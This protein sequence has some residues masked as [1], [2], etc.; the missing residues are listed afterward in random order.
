MAFD[1]GGKVTQSAWLGFDV[2]RRLAEMQNVE[3]PQN[4]AAPAAGRD[5]PYQ[6]KPDRYSSHAVLLSRLDQANGRRLLDVGAADGYLAQILTKRGFEV[7]CLEGNPML[8]ARAQGKCASV[9]VSD[10]NREVPRMNGTYDAIVYGDILEHLQ[11]PLN[12]LT[13]LNRNLAPGGMVLIS[14]P[15][16][17][18][19]WVRMQLILGRFEYADRGILD[20]THLRFFTL[21]SFKQFIRDSGLVLDELHATPVPLPLVVPERYQGRIFNVLHSMNAALARAWKTMFA[22]QFIG[23]C[24][25]SV[26]A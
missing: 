15:N 20:R 14:V 12:V 2:M 18:H 17:A 7:T 6:L 26:S 11:D 19:L 4:L 21:K 24:R 8:A 9:L 25:R 23:V 22:Y 16:V 1:G 5:S 13:A 10:L 3:V